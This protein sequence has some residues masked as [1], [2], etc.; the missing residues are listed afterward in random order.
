VERTIGEIGSAAMV[1]FSP[2]LGGGKPEMF[3]GCC[4]VLAFIASLFYP[5]DESVRTVLVALTSSVVSFYF[6]RKTI[7]YGKDCKERE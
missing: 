4:I 5:V 6:G 7:E 3:I 2:S 1:V